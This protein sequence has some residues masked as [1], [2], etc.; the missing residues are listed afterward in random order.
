MNIHTDSAVS[1]R[2]GVTLGERVRLGDLQADPYPIYRRL[3]AEEP[4]SFVPAADRYLVTRYEDIVH[5]ERNPEIFSADETKSLM[6]RVMGHSMLRKDGAAHKRERMAAE[7]ALRPGVV[8]NH[9]MP[10]FKT[11]VDDL[12]DDFVADGRTDLFHSFAAPCASRCLGVLLGLPNV[13]WQDLATWSQAMMDGTGNYADDPEI[14]RRSEAASAGVDA[15]LDEMIPRLRENPD[16]SIISAML[17]AADPL[18]PEE[19]APN[20]KVIIGGGLNEPRDA[21]LAG[22]IGLLENPD[23]R[24]RVEADPALWRSVFEEAVRWVSPIGMYPRQTTCETELGGVTLPKGARLGVVLASGNRD[25]SVFDHAERFDI[26]REKKPHI[27]FGGGPHFCLGTWAARIQVGE[28]ALPTLF[29]RLRNLRLDGTPEWAGWVFR[30]PV[31]LPVTWN[32]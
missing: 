22:A 20:V 16:N 26:N 17:H 29:S 25:E 24:A 18:T 30:G 13:P 9:W 28:V 1:D 8:K 15:A 4:V 14:W 32:N 23:Q 5:L 19:I 6:K 7:P 11:I 31:H 10:L 2:D 12:I 3:R 21:I 27:A